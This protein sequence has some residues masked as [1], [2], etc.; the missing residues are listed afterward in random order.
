[1]IPVNLALPAR[2]WIE[3]LGLQKHPEGGWFREVYRSLRVIPEDAFLGFPANRCFA[4]SI[5]FMLSSDEFSAFHRIKSDEIWHFYD[6][7]PAN[8]Y[9]ISPEGILTRHQLGRDVGNNESLQVVIPAGHWFGSK[10]AVPDSYM[11]AGCNVSPGFEFSDFE[12]GKRS[13]LLNSFPQHA[14]II[15]QLTK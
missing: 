12:M 4:T 6:G 5:Y 11:L 7:S 14:A 13:V 8:I 3:S 1:M 15:R 10:V 2:N 9:S